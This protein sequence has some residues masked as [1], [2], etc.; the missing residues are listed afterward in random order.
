MADD[1]MICMLARGRLGTQLMFKA[2]NIKT[3][4]IV[5]RTL[6]SRIK[7]NGSFKRSF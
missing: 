6:Y 1:D 5:V 2:R 4:F 7:S 3:L